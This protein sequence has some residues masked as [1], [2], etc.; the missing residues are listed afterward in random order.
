MSIT[1]G[2]RI[3]HANL[4]RIK[5]G[6]DSVSSEQVFDDHKVVLFAVPGAFT[7]TCSEQHLPGYIQQM[8]SFRELGI[9][10]ACLAVNDAFVMD[11]WAR[12]QDAP[13]DLIML[14][15]GN[16]ELTRALGLE[17]DG[18]GF[19]MGV[20]AQRFALYAE[21]GVVKILHVEAPGEFR[22]S[23]AQAMLEAIN[24]R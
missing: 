3:P 14:A 17:L 13:E 23:S 5:N 11:A 12:S 8:K 18:T 15:D 19:G 9:Q 2:E 1:L 21:N 20:R 16:A 6:V 22:V 7:P 10:V 24:A 4:N